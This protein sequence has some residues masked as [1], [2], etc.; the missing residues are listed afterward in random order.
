FEKKNASCIRV[1]GL[2]GKDHSVS[3]ITVGTS[4]IRGRH[5]KRIIMDDPVTE[6]DVS[7]AT[8]KRVQRVYNELNKL[9]SN[10]LVVGQPVHKLDLYGTLRPLLKKM[11]V[12]HGAIPELDHDLDAQRLA[13]VSE[14]SIQ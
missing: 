6:E 12:P 8:R 3:S 5:P 2:I 14:E 11:E 10:I 4:S 9:R 7:E 13:G 1:L